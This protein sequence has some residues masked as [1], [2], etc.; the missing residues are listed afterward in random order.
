MNEENIDT[1]IKNYEKLKLKDTDELNKK[2]SQLECEIKRNKKQLDTLYDH[3]LEEIIDKELYL[4][5]S[6][7]FKSIIE[8]CEKQLNVI[9]KEI[10]SEKE[11]SDTYEKYQ[12]CKEIITKFFSLEYPTHEMMMEII[13]KIEIDKERNVYVYFKVDFKRFVDLKKNK[14]ER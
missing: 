9:N 13:D 3:L 5:K 11:P 10:E 2:K 14:G 8:E 4:V 1:I 6:K 12:E 7:K